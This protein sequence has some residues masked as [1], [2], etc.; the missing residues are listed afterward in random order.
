MKDRRS[1]SLFSLLSCSFKS[2]LK[3]FIWYFV[4]LFCAK[5]N[6]FRF[7]KLAQ[8]CIEDRAEAKPQLLCCF[9][10]FFFY[11]WLCFNK[12]ACSIL[13]AILYTTYIFCQVTQY[14]TKLG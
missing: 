4:Q 7:D 13:L 8:K 11:L 9:L 10:C 12:D 14:I 5:G 6:S 3:I 2:L 1:F